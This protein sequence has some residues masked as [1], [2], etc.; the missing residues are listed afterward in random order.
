MVNVAAEPLKATALVPVK[1][2]PVMDT[3]VP[4]GPV[5]GEKLVIVGAAIVT[6]KES[7]DVAIP[8][9]VVTAIFPVLAPAGTVAVI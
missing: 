9:G 2:V 3:L 8:P 6:A 1:F 4:V 5:E 7:E